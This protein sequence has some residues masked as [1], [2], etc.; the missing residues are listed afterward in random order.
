MQLHQQILHGHI[1]YQEQLPATRALA[2][3]LK[4]ARGVIVTCY[5]MLKTDELVSGFGKGGTRV[6]YRFQ[7]SAQRSI[8][9]DP[10]R[11]S[12]SNRGNMIINARQYERTHDSSSTLPLTPSVPDFSLF[13]YSKWQRLGK[14]A[15][16]NAPTWYQRDGGVTL[17]K[18]SL[19]TYLSQ[20]R[21]IHIDNLDR[22]LITTGTQSSLS[23]L[24][25]LLAEPNDSALIDKPSWPG[26]TAAIKQAGLNII[27]APIDDQG[28]QLSDWQVEGKKAIPEIAIITPAAQFPTGRPMSMKRRE[29][30]IRY[31]A[32]NRTWLI[33]DDYAAEYSYAQHPSPSILSHSKTDHVIHVG[34]MSKL[35]LPSLRL[36]WMIVPQQIASAVN[37]ALNTVGVQPSYIIQQQLGLFIQHGYLSG[38]LMNTRAIYNERRRLCSDY[39][40][41]HA[42]Q[43]LFPTPSISGMNHYLKINTQLVDIEELGRRISLAKLGCHIY[44]QP[45]KTGSNHYL[46]LGH[47]NLDEP[48]MT[49]ELD[50]LFSLFY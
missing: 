36:G 17:L 42:S 6:S 35:L 41:R 46:L 50:K 39:L 3:E 29:E 38:H 49:K 15:I 48:V 22:L 32:E 9:T 24:T 23:L 37:N 1:T 20:Y 10:I 8:S 28:T 26:A 14:E 16:S 25:Q 5:E 45:T 19:Q 27:Y 21:G 40:A 31:T 11:M 18:R 43:W 33:E 4:V 34:T 47:A 12:L 30:I 44:S 7:N 2:S 13:P